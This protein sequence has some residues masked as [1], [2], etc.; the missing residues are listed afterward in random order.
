MEQNQQVL[1]WVVQQQL[2]ASGSQPQ[3][4]LDEVFEAL[5]VDIDVIASDANVAFL[6][7]ASLDMSSQDR[8]AWIFQDPRYQL[9]FRS[10]ES[11]MLLI[12]A[13]I[14]DEPVNSGLGYFAV[15]LAQVL[16]Q[17]AVTSPMMFFCGYHTSPE[18]P[19]QG[20]V[21][22]LR[23]LNSQLI[24]QLESFSLAF[25]DSKSLE[26]LRQFD[27]FALCHLFQGLLE[28]DQSSVFFIIVDEIAMYGTPH[29]SDDIRDLVRFLRDLTEK[30]N[31]ECAQNQRQT[32]LKILM[33][34]S[35]C[36]YEARA[37]FLDDEVLTI[38]LDAHGQNQ[39]FNELHI[40]YHTQQLF[41]ANVNDSGVEGA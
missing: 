23:T 15:S 8:I 10:Q 4:T 21:G 18:D 31:A 5:A 11:A 38:P 17:M 41:D 39:G 9:W 29:H 2:L 22:I 7:G 6:R 25:F 30:F 1:P 36:S 12:D 27:I 32:V 33:T 37:W 3:I 35:T 28:Q 20:A 24:P 26:D 16:R 40:S 34:C 14:T 19:L 13:S